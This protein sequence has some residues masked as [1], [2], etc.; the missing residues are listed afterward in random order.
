MDDGRM[1]IWL[2]P[3]DSGS[4]TR[5]RLC[6]SLPT[7]GAWRKA[8]SPARGLALR[9]GTPVD[10]ALCADGAAACWCEWWTG[11]LA[12][13]SGRHLEVRYRRARC[14]DAR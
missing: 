13:M 12:D 1:R 8:A 11:L 9:S 7:A 2:S 3:L 5:L 10:C 6:G 4:Y 14:G